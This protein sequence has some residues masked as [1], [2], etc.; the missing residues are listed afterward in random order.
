MKSLSVILRIAGMA[1]LLGAVAAL[2][3]AV[4]AVTPAV[5]V[6]VPLIFLAA[7]IVLA[8]TMFPEVRSFARSGAAMFSFLAASA[9]LLVLTPALT[10]A[11]DLTDLPPVLDLGSLFTSTASLAAFVVVVVQFVRAQIWKSLDGKVLVGF[12]FLTGIGLALGGFYMKLL[13]AVDVFSAIAFGLAASVTAIGAVN[14]YKSKTAENKT[15]T[16][17]DA[18]ASPTARTTSS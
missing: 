5:A 3:S 17:T 16:P 18:K 13:P 11:Q 8:V 15:D 9:A 7:T 10:F 12:I 6:Y 4:L 14:L 2:T 1:L